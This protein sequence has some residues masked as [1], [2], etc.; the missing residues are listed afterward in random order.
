[1]IKEW[2]NANPIGIE[3]GLRHDKWCAM[4]WPRLRLLHE[5]LADTGSFWIT[6]DDNEAHRA[7]LMLDEIFGEANFITSLV[8]E[9]TTS[10]RNDARFFSVDHDHVLVYAKDIDQVRISRL[11]RTES[12]EAAYTNP[13]D[14]TRGPWREGDYK[15][16]KSADERP[17]LY[18]P[19]K[20][21]FTKEDVWPR[22][23]RVW[24]Y[25]QEENK[26]HIREKRL[27]WGKTGNY[28]FPKLKRFRSEAPSDLVARTLLRADQV[29]QTRSARTE[30]LEI[31][32]DLDQ[33]FPTPKPIK[34]LTRIIGLAAET[35]GLILDSFAGSG[36]TAHAV[37]AANKSDGGDRRFILVET[38]DYADKLTA[39]RI[40]R[41]I[42]GYKFEGLT[43]Q[44]YCERI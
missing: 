18:Y 20:N 42:K 8:W 2:L 35:D 26:R 6:L 14:D 9:K 10:A 33:T 21:P 11:T 44:S 38:E 34:L 39:E 15:C 40:R 27:W 7:K 25:S 29:G 4:M 1:M 5:L 28:T 36:T 12:A 22:R 13:D 16:A 23:E 30:L 32:S 31:F 17:N 37:L 24:A 43:K 19:I 41:A 3:D